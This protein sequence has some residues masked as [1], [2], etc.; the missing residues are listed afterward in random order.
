MSYAALAFVANYLKPYIR[1]NTAN[2]L[3]GVG[4]VSLSGVT[5]LKID[6][7]GFKLLKLSV[8]ETCR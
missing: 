1:L 8:F 5:Q 4:L 6:V 2:L 7:F 3:P